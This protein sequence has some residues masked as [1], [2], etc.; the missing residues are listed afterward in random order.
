MKTSLDR[1]FRS[2]CI[3]N[4]SAIDDILDLEKELENYIENKG[5]N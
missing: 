3:D 5:E 1:D 4:I 2:S